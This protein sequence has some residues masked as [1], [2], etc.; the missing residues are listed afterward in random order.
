MSQI[1]APHHRTPRSAVGGELEC[2]NDQTI[3]FE[4]PSA[5]AV[6][7]SRKRGGREPGNIQ[8]QDLLRAGLPHYILSSADRLP[9]LGFGMHSVHYNI[10]WGEIGKKLCPFLKCH[11]LTTND[12]LCPL[13]SVTI[14]E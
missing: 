2:A 12:S 11:G 6:G 7:R 9:D 3:W 1:G 14:Y 8:T 10:S 5:S 13:Q 4:T